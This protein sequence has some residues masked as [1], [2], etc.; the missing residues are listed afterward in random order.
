[1]FLTLNL[2]FHQAFLHKLSYLDYFDFVGYNSFS[3]G[4]C[5]YLYLSRYLL[6]TYQLYLLFWTYSLII[7]RRKKT[8]QKNILRRKIKPIV[9]II[10]SYENFKLK[11]LRKKLY[12]FFIAFWPPVPKVMLALQLDDAK[13]YSK[14]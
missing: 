6:L 7:N 13:M 14:I 9:L 8:Q 11:Y 2:S 10:W 12:C 1:M 4:I 5:W 3:S